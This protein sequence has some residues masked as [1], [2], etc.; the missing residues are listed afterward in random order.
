[1]INNTIEVGF[2]PKTRR[3]IF[4]APF[5][6]VDVI[7]GFPSRR[8]DAKNK[9]WAVPLVKSNLTHLEDRRGVYDFQIDEAATTAIRD[10]VTL[11]A[12]PKYEPFPR[13]LY[14]FTKSKSGFSPMEHQ[15][16]M[17]DLAWGLD[18]CAMF[19]RMGT[20]KS[21]VT[22]H[23]TCARW[24][25]GQID[26]MVVICPST[27]RKTWEKEFA[28]YATIPYE[29][30]YHET[31]SAKCDAFR[32]SRPKDKLQV[33]LVSVEGLGV[34]EGY[35]DSACGFYPGR[36]VFSV[37]DESSR[38]K[39][40]DAKRTLRTAE[41][42]S[43]SRYRL[44]LNGTPIALGIQDLYSQYEFLDPN[45]IGMGDYWAFKT[46]YI[47]M[48]GYENRQVI[49][50]QNA[51]E[52]MKA[53]IP[54]TCEVGKEVLNLPP[55]VYMERSITITTEQKKLLR[56]AVK[57]AD[58]DPN[59]PMIKCENTLEKMLRCRQI[60]GGWLPRAVPSKKV[61][62][63]IECEVVDTVLEPLKENP[64]FQS[65]IELI[66]DNFV[67]SKFIVWS[68]FVH[69]IEAIH[70]K[71][72]T[73]YGTK[74]VECYYG[75]TDQ[76]AR[77]VIEDRYC[78]DPSFRFFIG[79]TSAGGLGLTLISGENDVM[80]YYSGTNAYIERAQSEDRAHRIGQKNSVTVVDLV[81]EGTVDDIIV[82][83]IKSKMDIE[84]YVIDQIRQG[85]TLDDLL[86]GVD[87]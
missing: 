79:N 83:S 60:V 57:G 43:V 26:S 15:D 52:L 17:M 54:Y 27:L 77:S 29:I 75:K 66:E 70:D 23:L 24:K 55:K 41:L 31:R 69:E 38:I 42:G 46:R 63:G 28:K 14:D 62:D 5:Y 59:A 82:A 61:I 86:L 39:N 32:D 44:I 87:T 78:N 71:L 9:T 11:M 4:K 84:T 68:S 48:G 13:H 19:A 16:K 50:V 12:A 36:R 47:V 33:L 53:V 37:V 76:D 21:F 22:V 2:N 58:K 18:A 7:R 73:I 81:A 6:L 72:S 65:L 30:C 20:G 45:I 25:A 67:G 8:F 56:I 3:L 74:S 80:V 64:K 35:Y 34:S 40:P 85:K 10:H 51:D 49:G 1:M